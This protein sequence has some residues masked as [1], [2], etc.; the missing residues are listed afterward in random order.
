M[1]DSKT[2][3]AIAELKAQH[4]RLVKLVLEGKLLLFKP[5]SKAQVS[6]LKSEMGK[7]PA[8]AVDLTINVCK[9]NCVHGQSHLDD[10]TQRF[11][12]AFSGAGPDEPGVIN[13]LLDMARG[14]PEIEEV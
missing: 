9:I 14:R 8:Q 5:M 11:P 10:L 1:T 2:D 12:I 4:G 3:P 6:N 13:A 7:S